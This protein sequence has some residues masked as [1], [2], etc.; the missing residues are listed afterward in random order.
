M[1]Q[2]NKEGRI[3]KD[4]IEAETDA[5]GVEKKGVAWGKKT[6]ALLLLK[7]PK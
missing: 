5:Q 3:E 1:W 4:F 6:C 7:T 2:L